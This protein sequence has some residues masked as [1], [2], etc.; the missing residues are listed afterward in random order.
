ML[1]GHNEAH[2]AREYIRVEVV[3]DRAVNMGSG[4]CITRRIEPRRHRAFGVRMQ[5][6]GPVGAVAVADSIR[7]PIFSA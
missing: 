4:E 3:S 7:D 5:F 1:G 6:D 2:I